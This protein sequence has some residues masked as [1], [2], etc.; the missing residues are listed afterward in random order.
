MM[1]EELR[2]DGSLITIEEP[3]AVVEFRGLHIADVSTRA[4]TQPRWTELWL[5]Q[6]T[7]GSAGYALANSGKSVLYHVPG[8]PCNTGL[9]RK[10]GDIPDDQLDRLIAHDH[11]VD[12]DEPCYPPSLEHLANFDDTLINVEMDRNH[13]IK[14]VT[15][16]DVVRTLQQ[17]RRVRGKTAE[18]FL[19]GPATRLLRMAADS[20]PDILAEITRKRPL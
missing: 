8:G 1:T 10:A 16:A 3:D 9:P 13:V 11:P 19:S 7:D 12:N 20:D 18:R 4:G 15:A 17:E 6:I 5:Y 2:H 14:C